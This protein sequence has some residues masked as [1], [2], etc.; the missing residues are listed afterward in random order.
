MRFGKQ[1][2]WHS[3]GASTGL[4]V[5][6]F[7]SQQPGR[8]EQR[9]RATPPP[10]QFRASQVDSVPLDRINAY[11]Q[12]LRFVTTP[13]AAAV[14]PVDFVNDSIGSGPVAG[15]EPEIGSEEVHMT[16]DDQGRSVARNRPHSAYGPAGVG[17]A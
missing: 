8:P 16:D 11:A 2:P 10:T 1:A 17:P 12:H 9:P 3:V 14:G 5:L 6:A 7:A 15:I 13:P 4:L